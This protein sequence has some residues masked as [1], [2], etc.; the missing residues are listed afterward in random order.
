MAKYTLGL[1]SESN[2]NRPNPET[3]FAKIQKLLDRADILFGHME[4]SLSEKTQ[5]N[6]RTD[7]L[8]PDLMYKAGWK[9][10]LPENANAWKVAGFD[11]VGCASNASGDPDAV[12]KQIKVLDELGIPHAGIGANINDAHKPAIVEKNGVKFGFL[13][14]TSVYWPQF[15]QAHTFRAGAATAKAYTGIIPSP[16]TEEMPGSMPTVKTWM[17]P[18]ALAKILDDV[19]KLKPQVDHMVISIH[20]GCSGAEDIQDYRT[21]LAHAV[22]DAGVDAILGHH[23]HRP[24]G[25]EIYK[26][27]PIFYSGG[28]IAFDWWFCNGILLDG[29]IPF[30]TFEDGAITRISFAPVRRNEAKLPGDIEYLAPDSAAFK[31]ITDV[32]R[33][34]SEKPFGLKFKVEGDEVVIT[35]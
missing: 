20:W 23:P 3:A 12:L 30:I 31:E 24:N 9:H 2:V 26:G 11:A 13:S 4:T 1:V 14:Y 19:A 32:I 5:I 8:L 33:K 15:V 7:D 21:E 28:N 25:I 35:A 17:D 6:E 27:K 29:I 22:I 16:R 34:L 10:S 18:D